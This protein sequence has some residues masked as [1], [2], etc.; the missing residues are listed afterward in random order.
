M[1]DFYE[2]RFMVIL[3]PYLIFSVLYWIVYPQFGLLPTLTLNSVIVSIFNFNASGQ[4]W[5]FQLILTFYIFYPAIVAYYK[6]IKDRF[7]IYT[8]IALFLS[9][10][11]MYLLGSFI[12]SFGFALDKPFKYLIYFLLGI[13]TN[14]NYELI[15]RSLERISMK[16]VTLLGIL[17]LILPFFSMFLVVDPRCSTQFSNSIPYYYQLALINS[18]IL[19]ICIFILCLYQLLLYKPSI[20]ILQKV[21]EY[22]YGIYLVHAFFLNFLTIYIFPRFSILPTSLNY[23]IILFTGMLIM[24]YFTVKLILNNRFTTYMITGKIKPDQHSA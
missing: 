11:M 12:P 5:Y 4:F 2:K 3:I 16:K 20:R 13:Y 22:S 23:Y 24:S 18:H 21:G 6:I 15:C 19:H 17:I 7:G 10:L 8:P 9:I 1:K 14:D